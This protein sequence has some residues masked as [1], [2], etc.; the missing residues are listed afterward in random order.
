MKK[1][2]ICCFVSILAILPWIVLLANYSWDR[3]TH[4]IIV[5]LK[6]G[7]LVDDCGTQKR[8]AIVRKAIDIRVSDVP[9]GRE[10][11]YKFEGTTIDFF[12]EPPG[13]VKVIAESSDIRDVVWSV[14]NSRIAGRLYVYGLEDY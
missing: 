13:N 7:D 8:Y 5:S 4:R 3:W 1:H 9:C 14:N 2:R 6:V 11:Q 12:N 10:G